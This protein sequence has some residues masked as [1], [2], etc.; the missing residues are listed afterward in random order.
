MRLTRVEAVA[1]LAASDA[2]AARAVPG[3]HVNRDRARTA[4]PVA[5][6]VTTRRTTLTKANT[7]RRRSG[8]VRVRSADAAV[9]DIAAVDMAIVVVAAAVAVV[10]EVICKTITTATASSWTHQLAMST[11]L[12]NAVDVVV[13]VAVAAVVAV[14]V[15][16]A[17][18]VEAAVTVAV[19]E[20]VEAGTVEVDDHDAVAVAAK[21]AVDGAQRA[22]ARPSLAIEKKTKKERELIET[23]IILASFVCRE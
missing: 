1:V 13:V 16:A 8:A 19:A 5:S 12:H 15:F 2:L 20:I 11:M 23:T 18:T 6:R 7:D 9:V 21:H 17:V 4:I 14:A 10:A 22:A 3:R